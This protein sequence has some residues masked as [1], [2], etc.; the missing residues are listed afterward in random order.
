MSSSSLRA[1][2]QDHQKPKPTRAEQEAAAQA[3]KRIELKGPEE[4][5]WVEYRKVLTGRQTIA[6]LRAAE[7]F[8]GA[9]EV[10]G[11][12]VTAHSFGGD[13]LDQPLPVLTR[14]VARWGTEEE[15]AAV[16]PVG[17]AD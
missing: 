10:V 3:T 17:A 11:Q 5:H 4:G 16:D 2:P 7:D 8:A 13:I 12:R 9:L 1:L 6:M 15:D 14:L